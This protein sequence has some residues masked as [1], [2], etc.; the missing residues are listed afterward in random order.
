[1]ET[2]II[3]FGERR[4]R[5]FVLVPIAITSSQIMELA[6]DQAAKSPTDHGARIGGFSQSTG[7]QIDI[8]DVAVD[9]LQSGDRGTVHHVAK[10]VES[11]HGRKTAELAPFD[12]ARNAVIAAVLDDLSS[13]V[14][15]SGLI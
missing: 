3:T 12:V 4:R 2:D 13:Q 5:K 14:Q 9:A 10:L 8:V 15:S 7:E 1:M 11:R 6:S